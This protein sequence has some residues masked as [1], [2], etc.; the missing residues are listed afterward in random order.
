M[1]KRLI[2]LCFV[3]IVCANIIY[4]PDRDDSKLIMPIVKPYLPNNPIIIEAGAFNGHESILFAKTWPQATIYSFEPVPQIFEL[5]QNNT[6]NFSQIHCFQLALSNKNGCAPFVVSEEKNR[7]NIPSAAGSLLIPKEHWKNSSTL[8]NKMIVV[9]TI[10]LDDWAKKNDI[11]NVDF[12]WLDTQGTELD[13]LKSSP[14]ILAT[15]KVIYIEVE[16]IEAYA[17]QPLY[18]DIKK[19]LE[20]QGFKVIARD[21]DDP[22]KHWYGNVV[23]VRG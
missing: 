15:V 20:A 21:F 3:N 13:I 12:L 19:F 23:F 6:K 16:F 22:P 1:F 18:S 2:A 10:I 5:L 14:G 9:P 4:I 7:P 8:F 17:G 11:S